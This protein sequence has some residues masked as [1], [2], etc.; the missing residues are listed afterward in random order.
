[1]GLPED[2]FVEAHDSA[3]EPGNVLRLIK[4]PA[5]KEQPDASLPRLSE[6]TD[7]GT[8][9]LLFTE[10]PGLEVS[11]PNGQGWVMAP[12]IED[13]VIVNIADGLAMWSGKTLK[14]TKHRL[15]WE[16]LPHYLDRHSMAYFVNANAGK[17]Q[18]DSMTIVVL[19]EVRRTT[20]IARARRHDVQGEGNTI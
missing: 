9:T 7:W 8:L 10:S 19:S 3:K 1:M 6:H 17:G 5:T 11:P 18:T 12:V 14:S 15:S 4:Y 16:S 2:Y 13:A 20:H